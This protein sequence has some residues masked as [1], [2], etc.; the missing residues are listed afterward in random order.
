MLLPLIP[1]AP[2]S[3][4]GRRGSLGVLMPKTRE[5]TQGLRNSPLPEIICVPDRY[6]EIMDFEE[7]IRHSPRWRASPRT[8]EGVWSLRN[9]SHSP[10]RRA[11]PRTAEGVW[12]LRN[13][14]AIARAGGLRLVHRRED[15]CHRP[16]SGVTPRVRAK[17]LP[18]YVEAPAGL[19]FQLSLPYA[20][21]TWI[22]PA[23]RAYPTS[24]RAYGL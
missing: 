18:E 8:A 16:S 3:H 21:R 10:R 19:A 7:I 22:D 9:Y 15:I 5:G 23:R 20:G 17:A 4:K 12:S 11:S 24:A 1:P 13:Y 6:A 2:F 14:S